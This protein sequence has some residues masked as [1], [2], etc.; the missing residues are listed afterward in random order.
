[1]KLHHFCIVVLFETLSI[2]KQWSFYV[3]HYISL[4]GKE[5]LGKN[6]HSCI[7]SQVHL[8]EELLKFQLKC[9]GDCQ[10]SPSNRSM[11]CAARQQ[12]RTSF[13]SLICKRLSETHVS[14]N[15]PHR[16]LTQCPRQLLHQNTIKEKH[17]KR[18]S[19]FL[20]TRM[21]VKEAA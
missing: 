16:N 5:R 6:T 2:A 14:S 12:E 10:P 21:D 15:L 11:C 20:S 8:E 4:Q 1:M 9:D 3:L 13:K 19:I 18:Y 7:K 17:T